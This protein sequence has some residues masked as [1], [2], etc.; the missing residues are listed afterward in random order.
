MMTRLGLEEMQAFNRPRDDNEAG[1]IKS[2][3][4]ARLLQR[5]VLTLGGGH[6]RAGKHRKRL[7]ARQ[8]LQVFLDMPEATGAMR[9][10]ALAKRLD[11]ELKAK[12]RPGKDSNTVLA[13]QL[14]SAPK[15][16]RITFGTIAI[17]ELKAIGCLLP[18]PAARG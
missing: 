4:L 5:P 3:W 18:Q 14:E 8:A 13:N 15:A 7:P 10:S 16:G 17:G 11:S 6:C 1:T 12:Q 9:V 2:A